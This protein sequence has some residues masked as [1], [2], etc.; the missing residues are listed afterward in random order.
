MFIRKYD[1]MGSRSAVYSFWVIKNYI[2]SK[3]IHL[4]SY[5]SLYDN[6]ILVKT[7][8]SGFLPR[9]SSFFMLFNFKATSLLT[10]SIHPGHTV[11]CIPEDSSP[12]CCDVTQNSLRIAPT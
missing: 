4:I 3:I 11:I 1:F 10:A 9:Y 7:V 5:A 6:V 8:I 12:F 2:I